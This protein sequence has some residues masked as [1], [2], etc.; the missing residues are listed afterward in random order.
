MEKNGKSKRR[1]EMG[2]KA[3]TEYQVERR[4]FKSRR[5][6]HCKG[7][8]TTAWRIRVKEKLIAYKG[9]KCEECGYD[10]QIPR[11]FDFHHRDP[12]QKEFAIGSYTVLNFEK[13]KNEVDK[14]ELV[15]KNCHAEIHHESDKANRQKLLDAHKE[16]KS[17]RLKSKICP[18][19][20]K[21]FKP[22]T[23]AQIGCSDCFKYNHRKVKNRPKKKQLMKMIEEMTWVAIGRKYNVS[24]NAVRKWARSYSLL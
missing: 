20:R 22:S 11:V 17:T 1:L 2:E 15:C 18:H 3:W 9:G 6:Y 13:L 16:W 19:C 23:R 5:F 8:H 7:K 14:C 12:K 4:R 21:E 24:D 10:K